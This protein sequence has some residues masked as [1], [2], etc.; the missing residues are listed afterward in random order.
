[1]GSAQKRAS[2]PS[3]R[4]RI[5]SIPPAVEPKTA[6]TSAAIGT[7]PYSALCPLAAEI[8]LPKTRSMANRNMHGRISA[9]MTDCASWVQRISSR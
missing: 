7:L 2:S 6:P 8:G 1:M 3:S 5:S 4:S 9:W